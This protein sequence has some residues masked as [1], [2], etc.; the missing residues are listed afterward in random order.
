MADRKNAFNKAQEN[1]FRHNWNTR[2]EK[3]LLLSGEEWVREN[4]ITQKVK[5]RW[6][7]KRFRALG[8]SGLRDW[9]DMRKQV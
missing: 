5:C 1:I 6:I 4:E 7:E 3:E 8:F 2:E 9:K